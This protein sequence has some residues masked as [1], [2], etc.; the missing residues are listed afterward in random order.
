MISFLKD[1]NDHQE[2]K[3]I[4]HPGIIK[5]TNRFLFRSKSFQSKPAARAPLLMAAILFFH[6]HKHEELILVVISDW[7]TCHLDKISPKSQFPRGDMS[8]ATYPWDMHLQ[9]FHVCANA[10]ILSPATCPY[11]MSLQRV[12]HK[13]YGSAAALVSL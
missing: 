10:V 12:L 6:V 5:I 13:F 2:K 4:S 1:M 7:V 9:H 11:Y 3:I 8:P